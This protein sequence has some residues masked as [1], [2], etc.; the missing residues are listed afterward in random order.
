MRSRA[1]ASEAKLPVQALSVTTPG[2]KQ[3]R[4]DDKRQRSKAKSRAGHLVEYGRR[5]MLKKPGRIKFS[6]CVAARRAAAVA[7]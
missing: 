3:S 7:A 6:A 2:K 1:K 5:W 4:F